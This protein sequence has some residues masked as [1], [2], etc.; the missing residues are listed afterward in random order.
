[1]GWTHIPTGCRFSQHYQRECPYGRERTHNGR[2]FKMQEHL[3]VVVTQ[4]H[5]TKWVEGRAICSNEALTVAD[6]VV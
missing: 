3:P 2:R 5:F 1:M 6:A 4:E